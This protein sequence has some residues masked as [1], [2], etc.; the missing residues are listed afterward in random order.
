[1]PGPNSHP[2]GG[3]TSYVRQHKGA[4][5]SPATC[6]DKGQTC[7]HLPTKRARKDWARR[8]RLGRVERPVA[9]K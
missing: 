4:A 6:G 3:K 2:I 5:H 8:T 7:V 9:S 1:M